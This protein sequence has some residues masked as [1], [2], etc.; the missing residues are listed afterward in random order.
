MGQG[1]SW[2]ADDQSFNSLRRPDGRLIEISIAYLWRL[3]A[4]TTKAAPNTSRRGA[5]QGM[6]R[7]A[8]RCRLSIA[9]ATAATRSRIP[10]KRRSAGFISH[11]QDRDLERAYYLIMCILTWINGEGM[12][13]SFSLRIKSDSHC[14]RSVVRGACAF[15]LRFE[16]ALIVRR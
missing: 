8:T 12:F 6:P 5:S 11:L 1:H 15:L 2:I 14:C 4:K 13:P 9:A 7:L 16:C 3:F 10:I